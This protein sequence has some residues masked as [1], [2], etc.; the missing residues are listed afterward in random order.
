MDKQ[1]SVGQQEACLSP[2]LSTT[3]L[4]RID[5]LYMQAVTGAQLEC[6]SE[7]RFA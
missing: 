2:H 6:D 1:M 3:S 5:D 7:C 4:E